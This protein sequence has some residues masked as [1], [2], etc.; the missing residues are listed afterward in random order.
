MGIS[1]AANRYD[2][3][4]PAF[5]NRVRI[6]AIQPDPTLNLDL[7]P[8]KCYPHSWQLAANCHKPGICKE[9]PMAKDKGKDKGMKKK[10][11]KIRDD[12]KKP[13]TSPIIKP[14]TS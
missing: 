3:Y 9:D 6:T 8:K 4:P 2:G 14:P 13:V 1:V 7:S 11:K 12:K 5:P 10:P